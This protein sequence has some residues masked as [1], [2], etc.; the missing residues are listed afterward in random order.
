MM[1]NIFRTIAAVSLLAVFSCAKE[2]PTEITPV[3]TPEENSRAGSYTFT[4]TAHKGEAGTRALVLDEQTHT[5]SAS[6]SQGEKVSVYNKTKGVDLEGELEAQESGTSTTLKGTLQGTIENGD[7]LLLKFCSPSYAQQTGTLAYIAAHCDYATAE[8][9][10]SIPAGSS[11]ITVSDAE[12][13]SQQAIVKFSLKETDGTAIAN[14]V[15]SL[16]VKRSATDLI[17]VTPA[18]A[19]NVLFVAIPA[20]DGAPL[21]LTAT[22]ADDTYRGYFKTAVTFAQSKYYEIGVKMSKVIP[23]SNDTELRAAIRDY[24]NVSVLFTADILMDDNTD[25]TNCLLIDGNRNVTID[26]NGFKLDRALTGAPSDNVGGHVIGVRNGSSVTI[27]DSSCDNSGRITGGWSGNGGGIYNNNGG[28]VIINGGTISGNHAAEQGGGIYN[29]GTLAINGGVIQ[30]NQAQ[31]GGGLY[32][33]TGLTMQG[34]PVVSGNTQEDVFLVT[35]QV[36]TVT[37]A[38]TGAENSIGMKLQ[39]PGVFTS[40]Y[41]ASGTLTNP[42]FPSGTAGIVKFADPEVRLTSSYKYISCAWDEVNKQVV[43]TVEYLFD[44]PILISPENAASLVDNNGG[45]GLLGWYAVEGQ[46]TVSTDVYCGTDAKLIL[47]DG[48]TLTLE[49]GLKVERV[50]D[51]KLTIYCQSYGGAMGKLLVSAKADGD[52]GIGGRAWFSAGTIT[53]HGGHIEAQGK[54]D[55]AGIGGGKYAN[56]PTLTIYGGYVEGHG[57]KRG[58]GIGGGQAQYY[59]TSGSSSGNGGN[60]KI[61]GGSVYAYGDDHGAGIGSGD[62]KG[63]SGVDGGEL[64][65]YGGYV[66]AVGAGKGAGIGGGRNAA[67]ASVYIHG[68]TVSALGGNDSDAFGSELGAG[69]QGSLDFDDGLR[70]N[71]AKAAGLPSYVLAGDRVSSCWSY[72]YA[73]AEPCDQHEYVNGKC[74]WCKKAE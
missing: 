9:E 74:K 54:D 17:T 64:L 36:I 53:I 4:V 24:N 27:N 50:G 19:A 65:V 52:A 67:G 11:N 37:G 58:A 26:L 60:V 35:G 62:S 15:K 18:P 30:G 51:N 7:E 41:G 61:Y 20:I 34:K 22:A 72:Q 43:Q 23:V 46:I 29:A 38:L 47:C 68:G 56:G 31:T 16:V 2:I 12:F 3:E 66:G 73:C 40:G 55:A 28:T 21:S 32:S 69:H 1:K 49:K 6:W 45:I 10:V 25:G 8:V 63:V 44:D 48:A 42:F 14:G 5:L 13:E 71:L 33:A 39:K 57:G 59:E 70:V